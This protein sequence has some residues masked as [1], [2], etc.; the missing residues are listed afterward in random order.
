[1]TWSRDIALRGGSVGGDMLIEMLQGEGV[2]GTKV[3]GG[4]LSA[5]F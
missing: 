2:D 5:M 4:Q 3:S 1:M